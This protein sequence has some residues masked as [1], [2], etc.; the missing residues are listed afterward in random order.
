MVPGDLPEFDVPADGGSPPQH[1]GVAVGNGYMIDDPET[2]MDVSVQPIPNYPGSITPYG[3][4]RLP[5]VTPPPP[6]PPAPPSIPQ[7]IIMGL[8]TGCTDQNA[9]RAFIRE[10]WGII[11]QDPLTEQDQNLGVLCFYEPT[12]TGGFGGNPDLLMAWIDD[13]GPRRPQFASAV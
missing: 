3:Y 6:P 1:V 8:P 10:R 7:E 9:V 12:A 13:S 11:R 2:G 4:C 5:F